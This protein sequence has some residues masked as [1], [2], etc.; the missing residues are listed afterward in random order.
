MPFTVFSF[1]MADASTPH[2]PGTNYWDSGGNPP[3]IVLVSVYCSNPSSP[4]CLPTPLA[5]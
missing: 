3:A 1:S 5:L 2:G 4:F